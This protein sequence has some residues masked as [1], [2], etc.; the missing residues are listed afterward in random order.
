MSR[1]SPIAT[2][3]RTAFFRPALLASEIAWRW[4]CG[5]AAGLM[6]LFAFFT[7]LGSI[8]VSN[9]DL[10]LLRSRVPPLMAEAVRH[11]LEGTGPRLLR[12]AAVLLPAMTALWVVGAAFG[13][14]ASLRVLIEDGR[15]RFRTVLGL[16]FLRAAA[17]LAAWIGYLG[18]L[19]T[20][21]YFASR[22]LEERPG[23]FLLI[24]FVLATIIAFFHG[25]LRWYLFLANLLAVRDGSDAFSAIADAFDVYRTRR[26]R[27]LALGTIIFALR[28][29][30]WI[31]V[32]VVSLL[33]T[34]ALPAPAWRLL[35]VVLVLITLA[36]F[37]VADFLFVARLAAYV[38]I[39][40]DEPEPEPVAVVPPPGP[41]PEPLP[42]A[43]GPQPTTEP[44]S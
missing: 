29:G 37:V 32:T 42:E 19:L 31:G 3:F 14:W 27:F 28:L 40:H 17:A 7:Y 38:D 6:L 41:L 43:H 30:L 39:L 26:A 23:L 18:A 11:L 36:Y 12:A 22:S 8:R 24:F 10:L 20:A 34:A 13:R 15:G 4:S 16:H 9:A 21:G 1:P 44:S 25:R 2:G 33:A 5:F 35:V